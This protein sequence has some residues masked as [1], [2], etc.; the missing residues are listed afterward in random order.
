MSFQHHQYN[1]SPVI[2]HSS[3]G[4]EAM[5]VMPPHD[6]G[7]YAQDETDDLAENYLAAIECLK[8]C[9]RVIT[10][11]K[12][13]NAAKDDRIANLEEKIVSMS[14][15]L[16]SSK[17][18][19]DEHRSTKRHLQDGEEGESC[20]KN[21]DSVGP[22]R[23]APHRASSLST[24]P[25]GSGNERP[26]RRTSLRGSGCTPDDLSS[27]GNDSL[28]QPSLGSFPPYRPSRQATRRASTAEM[29]LGSAG[30]TSVA[31]DNSKKPNRR[32]SFWG[33][34]LSR[35]AGNASAPKQGSLRSSRSDFDESAS[36]DLLD[37]SSRLG[38][39]LRRGAQDV[40]ESIRQEREAAASP[41][42]GNET[43]QHNKAGVD[44]SGR[45]PGSDRKRTE[46]QLSSRSFL[47][48]SGVVFPDSF[49]EVLAK[50][51]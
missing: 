4:R 22:Q 13:Q 5:A 25:G 28:D 16:A 27:L 15:E 50:G 35:S 29:S 36:S 42:D 3:D 48:K 8:H 17:A 23:R 49:E 44:P 20:G 41:E 39:F 51:L 2:C 10:A 14:L 31:T 7:V 32:R 19:E 24:A 46:L 43:E 47:E 1:Q 9:E 40:A 33:S 26:T 34:D 11:L 45:R 12:S 18:F 30:I 6:D 37:L 38:N 21:E